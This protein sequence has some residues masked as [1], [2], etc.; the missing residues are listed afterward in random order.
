MKLAVIPARGG[1]KRIPRKNIK[2]FCGQPIIAYS[3]LAAI[4]SGAFDRVLVSTDDDEIASVA[5]ALGAEVPFFR[6]KDLS[7]DITPT[8]PVVKH[9]IEW[10]INNWGPVSHVCCIYSTAPFVT[11]QDIR[12]AYRK[13]VDEKVG[14]YVFTATNM[15]FPIQRTFRIKPDGHCEMFHPENYNTRS[16]DLDEAYQDAGQFYWG[17]AESYLAAKIFFSTDSK[18]YLLPRYRVQDI[19]TL[20]DWQSAEVMRRVLLE[21]SLLDDRPDAG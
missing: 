13:L 18:P 1:S 19:D 9:A 15:A 12:Q 8:V 16:Q 6:P 5:L 4:G 7:D 14:G 17:S 21:T 2:P 11:A 20:E 3:I 10:A